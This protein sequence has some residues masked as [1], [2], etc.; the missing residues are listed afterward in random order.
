MYAEAL[1]NSHWSPDMR[2]RDGISGKFFTLIWMSL[3]R[4]DDYSKL[5]QVIAWCSQAASHYL[6]QRWPGSLSPYGVTRTQRIK[7]RKTSPQSP[8]F[9]AKE[10]IIGKYNLLSYGTIM[11]LFCGLVIVTRRAIIIAALSY[12]TWVDS[13][14]WSRAKFNRLNYFRT[15]H[16]SKMRTMVL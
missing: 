11:T 12:R 10:V 16:S 14:D 13:A 6:N 8:T 7:C 5:V 3:N 2:H 1:C 4:A 9:V 15:R